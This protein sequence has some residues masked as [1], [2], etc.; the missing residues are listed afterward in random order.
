MAVA[1][2]AID[3][4]IVTTWTEQERD[5]YNS[6]PFWL[7][8]FQ[9]GYRK[10]W[11]THSKMC[12]KKPWKPNMGSTMR[13][14]RKE[15]SPHI[16]QEAT[17]RELSQPALKDVVDVQEVIVEATLKHHKFES[18]NFNFYPSF[19]DFLRDH[20]KATTTDLA[21]KELRYEELFV[22]TGI[23]H[24]APFI[25]VCNKAGGEVVDAPMW[26]GKDVATIAT[27]GKN[28]V[29]R[30]AMLATLGQP[31]NLSITNA[32]L[33][34]SFMREDIRAV[35]W[36]GGGST[37]P[38]DDSP[39]A[40][41]NCL[42]LSNEAY[43]QFRFD[44]F[45]LD[46]RMLNLDIVQNG[47]KGAIGSNLTCR[48]EDLSLRMSAD[49][50]F[51]SPQ[52]RVLGADAYNRNESVIADL[53]K[54]APYE[55]AFLYCSEGYQTIDAGPPP[56]EFTSGYEPDNFK[57]LRWNAE[58]T[59]TKDLLIPAVDELGNQTYELNVYGEYLRAICHAD[60]GL[61]GTQRRWVIPILFRRVRGVA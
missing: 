61:V 56:S 30:Q 53:Y 1:I 45:L 21:E 40:G 49:G 15:P 2:P 37:Q 3:Q 54:N 4:N 38:A 5:M 17:P 14:V 50:T 43:N 57:Q 41:R 11:A 28:A 33:V 36:S 9:V 46:N 27:L 13:A 59:V 60:F 42:V 48:I 24:M 16:R 25:F 51:P 39:L 20:L 58:I 34:D 10:T 47:F 35:P 29:W 18:R 7:A 55:W 22:R 19:V 8:N 26:D 32:F 44:P 23:F 52:G 6:Y 12:G 31:G